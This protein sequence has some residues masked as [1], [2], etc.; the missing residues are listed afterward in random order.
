M[1]DSFCLY[2][3]ILGFSKQIREA[4]RNG[5][6]QD[7]FNKIYSIVKLASEEISAVGVED[8]TTLRM[9]EYKF[10]TDNL[11]LGLPHDTNLHTESEYGALLFSL[12]RY[13]LALASKGFFVR[14][15][16]T[17]GCLHVGDNIV[18]GDSLLDAYELENTKAITP[19]I[20]L[21]DTMLKLIRK[22]AESFYAEPIDSPQNSHIFVD[23]DG[24]A[25]INYLG[26]AIS[27]DNGYDEADW[28]LIKQHKY[29]V[30]N[31]LKEHGLDPSVWAKYNWVA[32]YHNFFCDEARH[33]NGYNENLKISSPN[34]RNRPARLFTNLKQK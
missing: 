34:H 30:E 1:K 16:L 29:Q 4:H 7:L 27:D 22:H 21:S 26:A 17:I 25:F 12:L 28:E 24:Q 18:F 8:K 10:F 5:T 14:G 6:Q 19:R 13:Q 33:L 32:N 31:S 23:S 3:D 20:I 11:V 2:L 9:W 15:A